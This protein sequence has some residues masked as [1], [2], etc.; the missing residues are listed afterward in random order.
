MQLCAR[1]VQYS[2]CPVC[3]VSAV[4]VE[5]PGVRDAAPGG[6]HDR[7]AMREP[8]RPGHD[9][10]RAP[11]PRRRLPRQRRVRRLSLLSSPLLISLIL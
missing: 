8:D 2:T 11:P 6:A 4:H 5:R 9:A 10:R 1:T 7:G 3:G